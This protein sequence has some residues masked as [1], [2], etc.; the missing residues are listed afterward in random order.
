MTS[1]GKSYKELQEIEKPSTLV[2]LTFINKAKS[3]LPGLE[4]FKNLVRVI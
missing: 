1:A 3:A 4:K 2:S